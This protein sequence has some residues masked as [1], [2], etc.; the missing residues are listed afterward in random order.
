VSEQET[1]PILPPGDASQEVVDRMARSLAQLGYD[2]HAIQRM[3]GEAY[4]GAAEAETPLEETP[5]VA[6]S[7]RV[8]VELLTSKGIDP[9]SALVTATTLQRLDL[10]TL[11]MPTRMASDVID[12]EFV[13]LKQHRDKGSFKPWVA[14]DAPGGVK[15]PV[16]YGVHRVLYATAWR[17]LNPHKGGYGARNMPRR[18]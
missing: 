2:R 5:P 16:L 17:D 8:L 12:L 14:H 18:A 6:R 7:T 9:A 15:R 13:T 4:V 1:N 11:T 3:I 10:T